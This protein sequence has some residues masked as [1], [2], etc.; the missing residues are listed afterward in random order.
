MLGR[1]ATS[2]KPIMEKENDFVNQDCKNNPPPQNSVH[3]IA[4][5]AFPHVCIPIWRIHAIRCTDHIITGTITA[6]WWAFKIFNQSCTKKTYGIHGLGL[7][8]SS[9]SCSPT[10]PSSDALLENLSGW[11][12]KLVVQ[13]MC[14]LK[15]VNPENP[16]KI[17]IGGIADS[18]ECP[19]IGTDDTPG[20]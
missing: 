11:K 7:D 3:P 1:L 18:F 12:D 10:A 5:M 2:T 14:H 6:A 13:Y 16:M 19:N 20:I 9:T 15:V 4:A 17:V 8:W